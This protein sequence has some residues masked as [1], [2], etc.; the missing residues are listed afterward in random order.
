MRCNKLTNKKILEDAHSGF[1][2]Y[3]QRERLRTLRQY[4]PNKDTSKPPQR[5]N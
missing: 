5:P 2:K 4:N 3:L 1:D